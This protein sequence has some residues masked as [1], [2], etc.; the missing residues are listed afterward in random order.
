MS[1]QQKNRIAG[2]ISDFAYDLLHLEV[3]TILSE[4][5]QGGKVPSPYHALIDI[6]KDFNRK[7]AEYGCS[8]HSEKF[9]QHWYENTYHAQA[10]VAQ[11]TANT[12]ARAQEVAKEERYGFLYFDL[13]REGAKVTAQRIEAQEAVDFWADSD[14]GAGVA[15]EAEMA[16]AQ[17][18]IVMLQRIQTMSD[19]IKGIL[20][21]AELA[22]TKPE[23]LT[24]TRSQVIFYE[25]SEPGA[26]DA[27][28]NPR[29]PEIALS[30]RQ[31]TTLRKI[32]EIRTEKI[33]MQT[34]I[35]LDG[36]VLSRIS[37]SFAREDA[38]TGLH[39]LHNLGVETSIG[40]W[41]SLINLV[42]DFF[43]AFMR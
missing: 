14:S 43:N 22:G 36:D 4:N 6:A 40:M 38:S 5:I 7:L 31:V 3:N 15:S 28:S 24:F 26:I 27:E 20:K 2:R 41:N 37:P 29:L 9:L 17:E 16:N 8:I 12:L 13:L 32:Y 18:K 19:S 34:T 35:G 33:V 11:G 42:K 21:D 25:S 10:L 23:E 1:N 30:T 39:R